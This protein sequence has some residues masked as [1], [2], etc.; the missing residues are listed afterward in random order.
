MTREDRTRPTEARIAHV[1]D[2]TV[3]YRRFVLA[4][5]LVVYTLNYMDRQVLGILAS[6]IKVDLRLTDAQLGF[7]G[8]LVFSLFYSTLAIPFAILAD[9]TSR[10]WVVTAAVALWSVCTG[11]CGL[12]G[13][14][15][16]LLTARAG[17]GIGEAGGVAPSHSLITSYFPAASRSR[18]FAIYGLAFPLGSAVAALFGGYIAS[19]VDWRAAFLVLGAVGVVMAPL[20][21][22]AVR[23]PER[24]AHAPVAVR[25]ALTRLSA[26]PSFWFVSLG[27]AASV[28]AMTGVAF[29]LPSLLQRSFGYD[30]S[31]AGRFIG[32]LMLISGVP[33]TL[34]G[35]WLADRY[36]VRDRGAYALIPAV[37]SI[38]AAPLLA[39]AFLM[40]SPGA[41]FLILLLPNAL[42]HLWLAPLT[43]AVQ[44]LVPGDA[45]SSAS[46]I[47][48]LI[49]NLVGLGGGSLLMGAVSDLLSQ[50]FGP[51][52]L[53]YAMMVAPVLYLLAAL[54]LLAA[55]RPLRR[56]W[57]E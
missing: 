12:A 57:V 22:I 38:V 16:H 52:S 28:M 30:L 31:G 41:L 24:A 21:R 10:T 53:R 5:L 42:S 13:S 3:A 54:L 55:V 47:Y 43:N 29:W 36:G 37:G 17:V 46:A 1:P 34:A 44:H 35:G 14:F 2:G 49:G 45:R 9:R 27:G 6:S 7:L 50:E 18:A 48:M 51:E 56:E 20:F 33:G 25:G 23:E 4:V 11:V 19:R 39:V 32:A 40:G 15:G 8:G 26:K